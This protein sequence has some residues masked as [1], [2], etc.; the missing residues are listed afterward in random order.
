M[1]D[2]RSMFKPAALVFA[3]VPFAGPS[4]ETARDAGSLTVVV[5]TG[6]PAIDPVIVQQ[7][8]DAGGTVVL[9]GTF[10]FGTSGSVAVGS[11][12]TL[13]GEDGATIVGGPTSLFGPLA[14]LLVD[15]PGAD[16]TIKRLRFENAARPFLARRAGWLTVTESAFH[17][18]DSGVVLAPT[19]GF[20]FDRISITNSDFRSI[21]RDA[22]AL[23]PPIGS[24]FAS[25]AN[26]ITVAR[27]S[28]RGVMRSGIDIAGPAG[29][30]VIDDNDVHTGS[31]QLQSGTPGQFV[32][33]IRAARLPSV[34]IRRN[35][36]MCGF[37]NGAGIRL[38]AASAA[39]VTEN[40]VVMDVSADIPDAQL[41]LNRQ[42]AAIVVQGSASNNLLTDNIVEGRARVALSVI[43]SE[44][45]LDR[46]LLTDGAPA[47]TRL[48]ENDARAFAAT[49]RDV[50][51]GRGATLIQPPDTLYSGPT[52]AIDDD[53][54]RTVVLF[55]DDPSPIVV[56]TPLSSVQLN[57][58]AN[59]PGSFEYV[60]ADGAVLSAGAAQV[61][62]AVFTPADLATYWLHGTGGAVA[63][64]KIDALYAPQGTCRGEPSHAILAPIAAD[65]STV[66]Q[67]G[68]VIPARFRV[69]DAAGQSIASPNVVVSFSL[70]SGP[71]EETLP[72]PVPSATSHAAFRWDPG[73]EQWVFNI[74][75]A[76]LAM[77][78][79]YGFLVALADGTTIDFQ[80][81]VR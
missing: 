14:T 49:F 11:A 26:E 23:V 50:E 70:V 21:G 18:T 1:R 58:T 81:T 51:V 55:W 6:D 72:R 42:S 41:N 75:T 10:N 39:L 8:V 29:V 4:L 27:N 64:A 34:A 65:G 3:L 2:R 35:R 20:A 52:A 74:A 48:I 37:P 24:N 78:G 12:V 57:A 77:P 44:F 32:Q 63:I 60:P 79:Q 68:R 56:G 61:L 47:G 69:C 67:R 16:V 43:S 33:G 45:A 76:S 59:I 25:F 73:D 40:R 17:N 19:Q 13:V 22:V 15:A 38:A 7:A 36:V 31:N 54:A 28:V 62:S 66:V 30:V 9:R 5:A 53:G 46:P 71:G 80:L